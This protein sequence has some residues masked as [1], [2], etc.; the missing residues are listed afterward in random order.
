MTS[1]VAQFE[2]VEQAKDPNAAT[3]RMAL[4]DTSGNPV[5]PGGEA[6]GE[7]TTTT[8]GLVKTAAKGTIAKAST[9][10]NNAVAAVSDTPTKAEIDAIVTA[11]N[12]LAA[13]YNALATSFNALLDAMAAAKSLE[14]IQ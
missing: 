13:K 8:P 3:G 12:Q 6:P 1:P 2:L 10:A 14:Q 4:F 5:K 11:Y 9:D 7:A